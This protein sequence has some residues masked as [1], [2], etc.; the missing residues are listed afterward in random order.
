MS[1]DTCHI[2][3]GCEV[4][5]PS[6]V[7]LD[8][9]LTVNFLT[10][11][12]EE[13][14][15]APT[16]MPRGGVPTVRLARGSPG[17]WM[18]RGRKS[19]LAGPTTRCRRFNRQYIKRDICS[20]ISISTT[21]VWSAVLEEEEGRRRERRRMSLSLGL[22]PCLSA[23]ALG[24]RCSIYCGRLPGRR[25]PSRG[26]RSDRRL[27]GS[28]GGTR[29]VEEVER[30]RGKCWISASGGGA[31]DVNC[32]PPRWGV[33]PPLVVEFV[34]LSPRFFLLII[35]GKC[36]CFLLLVIKCHDLTIS[37]HWFKLENHYRANRLNSWRNAIWSI[38]FYFSINF[39]SQNSSSI[40]IN[41]IVWSDPG[42]FLTW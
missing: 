33:S 27:A 1:P 34:L 7:G 25:G 6:W 23:N 40:D 32:L 17:G 24:G 4:E 8:V 36:G 12:R 31:S 2:R 3:R 22:G 37:W 39:L 5:E 10:T 21:S 38:H 20:S 13:R 11:W 41:I 30:T 28:A 35:V 9:V 16:P 15:S 19:C 26:L 29:K 18:P 42:F 14:D